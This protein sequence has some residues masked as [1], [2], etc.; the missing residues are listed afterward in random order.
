MCMNLLRRK[1]LRGAGFCQ[2]K[3]VGSCGMRKVRGI[4]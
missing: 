1:Y 3:C 4:L 2:S